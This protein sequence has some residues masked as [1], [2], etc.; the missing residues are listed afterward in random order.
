VQHESVSDRK[1]K[2]NERPQFVAGVDRLHS[3]YDRGG[4][5]LAPVE[6]A[7]A[8][9]SFDCWIEATEGKRDGDAKACKD[10]FEKALD[11]AE[12]KADRKLGEVKIAAAPEPTPAPAPAPAPLPPQEYY[13]VPFEFD[14]TVITPEGE[15]VLA[16]AIR[17]VKDLT[18]LKI[19]L[20]AHADRS[21]ANDYNLKLSKR[22]AEVILN[23]LS[24]A[25]IA[26][27]RLRIVEAVGESRS[28]IP[29]P[30]GVKE[31]GNRVVELDLRQ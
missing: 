8:Q 9:V 26:E 19:A 4:R 1:L 28:L 25:G 11:A 10:K 3:V 27:S 5:D 7:V 18:Q 13:R 30:D 24:A 17:D 14:K 23:R 21:G 20:R 22:R 29:T 12:A 15:A 31:Q 2:E 16:Q 6:T